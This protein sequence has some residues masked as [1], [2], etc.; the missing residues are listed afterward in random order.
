MDKDLTDSD[1][2]TSQD[3]DNGQVSEFLRSGI[4]AFS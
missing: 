3:G 2:Q 1:L 4:G